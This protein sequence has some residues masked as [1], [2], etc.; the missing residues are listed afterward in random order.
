MRKKNIFI[1]GATGFL[2]SHLVPF[3]LSE[4]KYNVSV[5]GRDISKAS[6]F[7]SAVKF[8]VGDLTQAETFAESLNDIDA[9]IHMAS[10]LPNPKTSK[11]SFITTNVKGTA[12]LINA[13][14]SKNIKQ[15]IYLSSS[16]VYGSKA[17]E[18]ART[19]TMPATPAGAYDTSKYEAEKLLLD[20]FDP[21]QISLCILRPTG[22]YGPGDLKGLSLFKNIKK[23]KIRFYLNQNQI[24]HPTH[25]MDVVHAIDL[26]LK[27]D[28]LQHEIINIGGEKPLK[29]I[30]LVQTTAKLMNESIIQIS[31][32]TFLL[33]LLSFILKSVYSIAGKHN[34][35]KEKLSAKVINHSSDI[36]KAKKLIGFKPVSFQKS[37]LETYNWYRNNNYL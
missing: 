3:L 37:I 15:F 2:G 19:E 11:E 1:T 17:Y 20:K 33:P 34:P 30:E 21:Q 27:K 6:L 25:V 5:L 26:V 32:P 23:N 22:L 4:G 31:I 16:A 24:V 10:Q 7:G 13:C 18:L 28:G 12:S 9:V 35:F 36:S 14:K 29:L 8:V